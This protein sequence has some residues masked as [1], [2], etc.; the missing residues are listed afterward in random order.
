M[1]INK[2]QDAPGRKLKTQKQS[3]SAL[4]Q[5]TRTGSSKIGRV[6][7]EDTPQHEG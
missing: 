3:D 1:S 4:L 5:K 2:H 6:V 7:A